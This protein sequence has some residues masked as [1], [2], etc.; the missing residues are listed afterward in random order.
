[1]ADV[2][3]PSV[4][5]GFRLSGFAL[6]PLETTVRTEM[7]TG[8]A[9]A[10]RRTATRVTEIPV[11]ARY[12]ESERRIFDAWFEHKLN[13]GVAWFNVVLPFGDGLETVEARFI[14]QCRS[15]RETNKHWLVLGRLEVRERP[16]MS[17]AE[18]DALLTG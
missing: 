5:P 7:E 13:S 14:G 12:T 11:Q 4:L 15:D 3:Y 10:R 2:H 17:E 16:I 9:R 8:P 6:E 1:M 18:L